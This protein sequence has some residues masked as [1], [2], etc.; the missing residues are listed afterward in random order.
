MTKIYRNYRVKVFK[1]PE[2]SLLGSNSKNNMNI[3]INNYVRH[4]IITYCKID[5]F[6]FLR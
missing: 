4:N 5:V 3:Q 1:K 2:K 6:Y